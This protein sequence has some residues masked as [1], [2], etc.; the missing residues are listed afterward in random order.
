[1]EIIRK[2]PPQIKHST[3]KR[4]TGAESHL[5]LFRLSSKW[6]K[7]YLRG[8]VKREQFENTAFKLQQ[9]GK[10]FYTCLQKFCLCN[11]N[12]IGYR[13]LCTADFRTFRKRSFHLPTLRW[14]NWVS[15]GTS[16]P[17]FHS[18]RENVGVF[19][20]MGSVE[21]GGQRPLR[22]RLVPVLPEVPELW[23]MTKRRNKFLC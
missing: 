11:A 8:K 20:W 12:I 6:G 19:R 22:G 4:L 15:I 23:L 10:Q 1:M 16:G 17:G 3:P 5:R 18:R 21:P 13:I 7:S 14:L 9:E 2:K